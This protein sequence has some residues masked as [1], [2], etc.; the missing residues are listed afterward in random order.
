[1]DANEV[2]LEQRIRLVR[3]ERERDLLD[4]ENERL[5]QLLARYKESIATLQTELKKLRREI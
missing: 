4:C 5:S 2:I 1:V 3:L